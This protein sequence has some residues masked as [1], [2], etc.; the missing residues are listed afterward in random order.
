MLR[1]VIRG[2]AGLHVQSS[3]PALSVAPSHVKQEATYSS[4][5]TQQ[6]RTTF[7]LRR[8]YKPRLVKQHAKFKSKRLKP[9]DF[10]YELVEDTNIK[11]QEPVKVILLAPVE[12]LGGQGDI[13][14][15]TPHRARNKLILPGLAVYASEENLKK[16]EHLQT[17]ALSVD[18]PSSPFVLKTCQQ[19]PL[20]VINISMNMENPWVLEPWHVRVSLR[21]TG[22]I[23][24]EDALT[25]PEQQ[26][27]GPNMELE[28]KEFIVHIKLNKKESCSVRCR[29][30]HVA[31]NLRNR[32]PWQSNHW[33]H[34]TEPIFPE[35]KETLTALAS[36]QK[37]TIYPQEELD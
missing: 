33:M 10:V 27:K 11:P 14:E 37:H 21:K 3:V 36:L 7:V 9:K 13:L 34:V 24:P 1:S 8:K 19:I 17:E 23:V 16:Y 31:T 28:N 20:R 35:D 18:A 4:P 29:I 32:I 2:L 22:I 15:V 6:V 30:H 12:G 5:L 25:L 26:I